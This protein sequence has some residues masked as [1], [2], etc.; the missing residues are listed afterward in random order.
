[1]RKFNTSDFIY[2]LG[3]PVLNPVFPRPHACFL[4]LYSGVLHQIPDS[5]TPAYNSWGTVLRTCSYA[6][7]LAVYVCWGVSIQCSSRS[8]YVKIMSTRSLLTTRHLAM[9]K[10]LL[11]FFFTS[12]MQLT[13]MYTRI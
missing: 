2:H 9:K 6:V 5:L 8:F 3:F 13:E 7:F 4:V 12:S 11:I 1:M 10:S